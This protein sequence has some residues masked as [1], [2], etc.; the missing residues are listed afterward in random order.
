MMR[1]GELEVRVGDEESLKGMRYIYS[2]MSISEWP[3]INSQARR[4]DLRQDSGR[5]LDGTR[6]SGLGTRRARRR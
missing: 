2:V 4:A 6:D 5:L 1:P 3:A